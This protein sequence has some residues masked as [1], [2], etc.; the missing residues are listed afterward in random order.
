MAFISIKYGLN[1]FV[2][3]FCYKWL[4]VGQHEDCHDHMQQQ[5]ILQVLHGEKWNGSR[6]SS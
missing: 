2:F 4:S 5:S 1:S 6:Q 3:G